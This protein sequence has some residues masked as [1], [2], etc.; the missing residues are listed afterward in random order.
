MSV[1]R[2]EHFNQLLSACAASLGDLQLHPQQAA[3]LKDQWVW[4]QRRHL[5]VSQAPLPAELAQLGRLRH[6]SLGHQGRGE[7]GWWFVPSVA[8]LRGLSGEPGGG[9]GGG[10]RA[11]LLPAAAP[12][13]ALLRLP[14]AT[15]CPDAAALPAR[16]SAGRRPAHGSMHVDH[17]A[18]T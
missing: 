13:R 2:A 5:V 7:Q 1:K 14:S 10:W 12:R 6:L 11:T 8:L 3:Q 18:L 16:C 9:E 15:L 17:D 4:K